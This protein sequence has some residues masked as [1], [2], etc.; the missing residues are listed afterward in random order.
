MAATA[1]LKLD[2]LVHPGDML[3]LQVF[4][5]K[6]PLSR[7]R[8]ARARALSLSL[9]CKSSFTKCLCHPCQVEADV[10]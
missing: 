1:R 2:Q 8:A 3:S 10:C 9:S 4:I 6:V 7:A 5:H